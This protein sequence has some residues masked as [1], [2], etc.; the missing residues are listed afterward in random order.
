MRISCVSL[1]GL[2]KK[3]T[4]NVVN[5]NTKHYNYSPSISYL[6]VILCRRPS[7]F[8]SRKVQPCS[9]SSNHLSD[10]LHTS[11]QGQQ[12]N[13]LW[14][15]N[16]ETNLDQYAEMGTEFEL[17]GQ[18]CKNKELT[19]RRLVF[20]VLFF[21]TFMFQTSVHCFFFRLVTLL[22]HGSSYSG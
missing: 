8:T 11:L 16:Q 6:I 20:L 5:R 17:E 21:Q 7:H 18:K 3:E 22:K 15:R 4:A 13:I 10:W 2:R 12:I 9:Y 1:E 19:R 14:K